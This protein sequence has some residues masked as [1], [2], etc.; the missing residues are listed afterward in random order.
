MQPFEASNSKLDFS[1]RA[2]TNDVKGCWR[3]PVERSLPTRTKVLEA[4]D[5]S[6]LA[7]SGEE[8]CTEKESRP[9][10]PLSNV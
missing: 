4:S 9:G 5:P 7:V 1:P 8:V 6:S 3:P 10:Q 2:L